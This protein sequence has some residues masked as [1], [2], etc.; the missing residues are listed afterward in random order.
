MARKIKVVETAVQL[1]FGFGAEDVLWSPPPTQAD[2]DRFTEAEWK[3]LDIETT[4]LTPA[5]KPINRTG[6]EIRAGLDPTLRC[7]IISVAIPNVLSPQG[8][9]LSAW[10]MDVLR[11]DHPALVQPLAA[12][13]LTK[14]V[15]GHNVGFDLYWLQE[16]AEWQGRPDLALDSMLLIRLLCP[17]V[18]LLRARLASQYDPDEA[19]KDPYLYPT[20]SLA[21]AAWESIVGERSGWSLADLSVVLLQTRMDKG[22]QGPKNWAEPVMTPEHYDYAT[23]DVHDLLKMLA[24]TMECAI[25]D[26]LPRYYA[27]RASDPIF[28]LVEP[29]VLDIL[30]M[31]RHGIP[32]SVE[33]AKRFADEKDAEAYKWAQVLAGLDPTL[34]TGE[35]E[36][37]RWARIMVGLE[38]SLAPNLDKHTKTEDILASL[39]P[40]DYPKIVEGLE[41]ALAPYRYQ[42]MQPDSGLSQEGRAVLGSCFQAKG[43]ELRTTEKSGALQV[44]EKD[45]RAVK[46]EVTPDAR[47]LFNAWVKLSKAKKVAGMAL[48]VAGF[49]LRSHDLRIHPLLSHGPAT[50]R[51]AS[52]EPNSQQAPKD[53]GFRDITEA[54]EGYGMLAT[55]YS[56]L[57][58][59]VG[60]ALAVRAQLE[61]L[62][63]IQKG[64]WP[65]TLDA[66]VRELL[67]S[68]DWEGYSFYCSDAAVNRF[69]EEWTAATAKL[70]EFL[71]QPIPDR[72]DRRGSRAYWD[73]R[74][75]LKRRETL[76]RFKARLTFI[77]HSA[78]QQSDTTYSALRDAFKD[79]IDIHTFT[80][81]K[82]VG[83]NPIAELAGLSPD[84]SK[85]RQDELKKELGKKRQNG[86][87][88]NLS[89]LYAMQVAGMLHTA[90]SVYNTHWTWDEG[91][92]IRGAWFDAFPEIDLWALWTEFNPF[93]RIK[94]P[95]PEKGGRLG[96]QDCYRVKTLGGRTIF[97]FGLNAAL[98]YQDQSTGADI[99]GTCL[100]TMRHTEPEL[101]GY[102]VNQVHDEIVFEVPDPR[103]EWAIPCS[104]EL[105][106]GAANK[107]LMPFGVPSNCSPAVGKTWQKD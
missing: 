28:E 65:D 37:E 41:P 76:A 85:K 80:A 87:I 4:G 12:A 20:D 11:R 50:G 16:M 97:T 49:A 102:A 67:E 106:D 64:N 17:E 6:A 107:F 70:V 25:P 33:Q 9:T 35:A 68:P 73:N 48:E 52:S 55:D 96:W 23:G 29:Q 88:A 103:M 2:L 57:D 66:E 94:M 34:A 18:P 105:M 51:L 69:R 84:A 36:I 53:Q 82:M 21:R 15:I 62:E 92:E 74:K 13:I 45:L 32:T 77:W 24:L 90:S 60:A 75:L 47:P 83:R 1:G 42:L 3:A 104:Q 46:A 27:L 89:L 7:R 79:G 14:C 56:A 5:S 54:S 31:R 63:G 81:M 26:L 98:A 39:V 38:P 8:Y 71:E 99:V 61:I 19:A 95:N 100:N 10:D 40:A 93:E 59:R 86:K 44:G 43:L 101:Y 22:K 30:E 78:Q 58:M 91:V 72:E